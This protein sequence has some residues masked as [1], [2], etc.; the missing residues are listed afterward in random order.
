M[1]H[2]SQQSLIESDPEKMGGTSVFYGTRVPIKNLFDYLKEGDNLERFLG[3][4]P[5][6]SHDQVVGVLELFKEKLLTEY[7][8]AA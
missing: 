1:E 8:V 2:F 4:F 3:N 6:V 5:T 7:E